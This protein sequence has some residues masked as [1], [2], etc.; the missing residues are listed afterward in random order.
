[1]IPFLFR[2]VFGWILTLVGL[3]FASASLYFLL[4]PRHKIIEGAIAAF[5][6][7]LVFRA[8]ISLQKTALAARVVAR[9]LRE[10]RE[11]RERG[12]K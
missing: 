8:G 5:V 10:S 1:M 11:A 2:E 3:A 7:V 9:E 4:E 6:G 12:T